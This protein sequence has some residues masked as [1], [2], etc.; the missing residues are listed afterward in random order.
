MTPSS[1]DSLN[2]GPGDDQLDAG[3]GTDRLFSDAGVDTLRGGEGRDTADFSGRTKPLVITLGSE[4]LDGIENLRGGAGD[5]ALTGDDGGNLLDGGGGND[6]LVGRGVA[7]VLLGGSGDDTLD[8]GGGDDDLQGEAGDDTATCGAGRDIV[9]S[10]ELARPVDDACERVRL[11]NEDRVYELRARPLR[12]TERRVW[13]RFAC[14]KVEFR[15]PLSGGLIREA[16]PCG[17]GI[18]LRSATGSG[19]VL[20]RVLID[21]LTG[22]FNLPIPLLR[23]GIAPRDFVISTSGEELPHVAWRIRL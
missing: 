1:N 20:G 7:D 11:R 15:D 6:T 18:R 5:D 19:R 17:G 9:E 4:G 2:G 21:A 22:P 8:G 16:K 23:P 13:L 10:P 14:P 12:V 3:G